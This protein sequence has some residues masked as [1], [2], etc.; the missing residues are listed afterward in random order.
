[1]GLRELKK[2]QTRQLI[3]STAW[4]LFS[5]R[6]FDRVSVAEVARTAQVSE[7]TVFNYFPTKE[8]LFYSGL[9]AFGERL[10]NA[11]VSRDGGVPALAAVRD[12]LSDTSGM[13]DEIEAGSAEA[14]EQARTARRVVLSSPALLAR[15]QLAIARNTQALANALGGDVTA[16]VAAHA[17]IGVHR[18][19]L[20]FVRQRVSDED[21]GAIATDARELVREAFALLEKGLRDYT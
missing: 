11:V 21:P 8:D 15:E 2:E 13:L 4:R 7:A 10:I 19:L 16:Q 20:D 17:F 12:F 6:G 3:M 9:E 14:L 18:T 1:M 5:E